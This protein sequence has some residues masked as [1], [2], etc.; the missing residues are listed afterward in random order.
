MQVRFSDQEKKEAQDVKYFVLRPEAEKVVNNK[1]P[2]TS[3]SAAKSNDRIS[4]ELAKRN[5]QESIPTK[6]A[7]IM[8]PLISESNKAAAQ[9]QSNIRNLIMK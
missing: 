1:R 7:K 9:Q 8:R 3:T 4:L 2:N 6:Q 5:S